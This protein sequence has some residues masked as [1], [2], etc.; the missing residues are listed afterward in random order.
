MDH[1]PDR[2]SDLGNKGL[3]RPQAD[4]GGSEGRW[5]KKDSS[6]KSSRCAAWRAA[7]LRRFSHEEVLGEIWMVA[8]E[9][10]RSAK[11]R[12]LLRAGAMVSGL[13]YP[14][15]CQKQKTAAGQKDCA[16][17]RSAARSD[18]RGVAADYHVVQS[19]AFV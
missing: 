7:D 10:A 6:R 11:W 8:L 4:R 15:N 16:G 13:Q 14:P 9:P 18:F 5:T 2:F 3:R 19:P 12:R 17:F 1:S